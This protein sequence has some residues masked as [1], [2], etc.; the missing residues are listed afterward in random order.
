[1]VTITLLL[2]ARPQRIASQE[3]GVSEDELEQRLQQLYNLLPGALGCCGCG[4][5]LN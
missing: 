1:V 5:L 4:S 3:L 2:A